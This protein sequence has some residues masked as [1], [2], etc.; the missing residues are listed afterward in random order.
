MMKTIKIKNTKLMNWIGLSF[1]CVLLFSCHSKESRHV[2]K[3]VPIENHSHSYSS[4]FYHITIEYPIEQWD[5][6]DNLKRFV[7][8]VVA[9]YKRDWSAGGMHYEDEMLNREKYPDREYPKFELNIRFDKFSSSNLNSHSYLF[10]IY[11]YT[12]GANGMTNLESFN[13]NDNGLIE[14]SNF[15][16]LNNKKEI[17]LT[18]LIAQKAITMPDV[19]E[20]KY[21]WQG[22]GLNYLKPDG[23]T[24]DSTKFIRNHFHFKDNFKTFVIGDEGVHFY[25]DKYKI[26]QGSSGTPSVLLEWKQLT[27]FVNKQFISNN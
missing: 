17:Q 9:F 1:V 4:P 8:E 25:Y 10:Y 26:S 6:N 20:K 5:Y 14:Q 7:D 18:R 19:F 21:I 24:I 3:A 2:F 16:T 11:I 27:P 15:F 13:F 12:G 22:L 23:M